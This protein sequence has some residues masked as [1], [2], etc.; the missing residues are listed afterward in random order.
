VDGLFLAGAW[1]ATG[2]PA[3][4]EGAVRS[5]EDAARAALSTLAR[6]GAQGTA[7]FDTR[8]AVVA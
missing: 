1:T 6:R 3:T 5:G 2:W 4:M 7:P 8:Q